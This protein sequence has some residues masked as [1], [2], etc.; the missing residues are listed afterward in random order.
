MSNDDFN[1]ENLKK[2]LRIK[3]RLIPFAAAQASIESDQDTKLRDTAHL[4][5]SEICKRDWCPRASMYKILGY[6]PEKE[7]D[8]GFQTLNI[9]KT[10]HDIHDKWQGWLER[11][12]V[13]TQKEVPLYSEEY[14]I[15]GNADGIILDYTGE[16]VLEIKS[17]GAGTVRFEN[18]ELY[19]K[20]SKQEITHEELWTKIRQPFPSHLRQLNIYMFVLN[21]HSG[22][23]L[24][25]WK[26]TQACKEFE[27][28][29]QKALI[30]PIL[31]A[32]ALVKKALMDGILIARPVWATTKEH[33]TC[34]QCPFKTECWKEG[35]NAEGIPLGEHPNYAR[36]LA[37][38]LTPD[39]PIG[40]HSR[41][42]TT[43]R[44]LIRQ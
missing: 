30:E 9:F 39:A 3:G 16:A 19:Y 35:N 40:E 44:Q 15:K 13:L 36:I 24:Y 37:E 34:K 12:G 43:V 14:H 23:V 10:G 25:E 22:I 1:I 32:C 17:V 7:R 29:L 41:N 33:T 28:K 21:I 31:A 20:Y 2:Q 38:V 8:Y 26:A 18:P 11:A 6:T 42:T 27:V 4:H 5:P